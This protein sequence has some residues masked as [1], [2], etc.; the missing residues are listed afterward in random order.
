MA[1]RRMDG[2]Y[3]ARSQGWRCGAWMDGMPQ[4]ARDG[5]ARTG[6]YV[7]RIRP[8][9]AAQDDSTAVT[10]FLVEKSLHSFHLSALL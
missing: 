6:W 9:D 3:A 2:R 5:G 8:F 7:H 1:V 10:F 4:E